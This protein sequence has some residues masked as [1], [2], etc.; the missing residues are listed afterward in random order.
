MSGKI[1]YT[2]P[3]DENFH[4]FQSL[5]T[6]LYPADSIRHKQGDPVND[7]FLHTCLVYTLN[8]KPVARLALYFNPSLSSNGTPAACI[9]NYESVD[10]KEISKIL[11]D[12]AEDIAKRNAYRY[13]LGPMNGSTWDNYRFSLHNNYSNFFLEPYHHIYYNDHFTTSG[14]TA[15]AQYFTMR[16]RTLHH[17]RPAVQQ[18]EKEL[19][20]SGVVFRNID[21]DDYSQELDRM[22]EFSMKAFRSNFLFTPISLDTFKAKYLPLKNYIKPEHVIIAQQGD[23][24]AGLAFCIDDHYS[25][26]PVLILKTVARDSNKAYS[27]LGNV[28]GSIVTRYAK[29]NGYKAVL[30]AFMMETNFSRELS[31]E[32]SGEHYKQYL[33]YSKEL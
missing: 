11:L 13:I 16:D 17:E 32:Y 1:I 29:E 25:K 22:H 31:E 4:L 28:L 19:R 7:E 20:E 10:S 33:L 23:Q 21:L 6:D 24:I 2:R 5:L 27:G 18:R 15:I 9:G 14:Y 12:Y 3:G 26:D 8:D 30:H